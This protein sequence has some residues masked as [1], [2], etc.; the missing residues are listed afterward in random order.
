MNNLQSPIDT[1]FPSFYIQEVKNA[2]RLDATRL[3]QLFISWERGLTGEQIIQMWANETPQYIKKTL[4]VLIALTEGVDY[5]T[6]GKTVET[7]RALEG[8][9][10]RHD[11]ILSEATKNIIWQTIRTIRSGL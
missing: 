10:R 11:V 1:S 6:R 7:N 5:M 4:D 2:L 9:I 8:F 3:G